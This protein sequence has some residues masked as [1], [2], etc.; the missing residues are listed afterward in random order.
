MTRKDLIKAELL[1]AIMEV[2][3]RY[4]SSAFGKEIN[5]AIQESAEDAISLM[6]EPKYS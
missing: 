1:A 6:P 5:E 2:S 3:R 4:K